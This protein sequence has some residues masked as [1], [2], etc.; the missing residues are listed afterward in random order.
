MTC[1][2]VVTNTGSA[3]S[4]ALENGTIVDTLTGDLLDA[5]NTAVASSDCTA[6]LPTGG[7]CTIVTTRTV[8]DTD[9]N[10]LVNAVTVHYNPVGFPNDIT[11]TRYGQRDR[12]PPPG[13]EGCTPGFWK[14]DQ[15]F[16]SWVGFAPTD[17]FETV[18]GVDVTLRAGGQGTIDEPDPAGCAERQRRRSERTR[19]PRRRCPAQRIQPGC[20]L[21]LHRRR[22]DRAGPRRDR[23]RRL[24]NG[25]PAPRGS[26]RARLPVELTPSSSVS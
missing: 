5:T 4:P 11:D 23:V 2:I 19:T 15:H 13:G 7:S 9:P 16:D 26:E 25:A 18:F 10:P 3:D 1:T 24:R 17:S 22:G 6:A 8:L 12:E 21:R 20:G 14:Q